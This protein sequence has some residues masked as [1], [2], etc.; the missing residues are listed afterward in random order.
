MIA[1]IGIGVFGMTAVM[2]LPCKDEKIRRWGYVLGVCAQPFWFYET[3]TKEQWGI[4]FLSIFYSINW[5]RGVW[6]HWV[7]LD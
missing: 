3:Y 7:D 2:L 5:L 1:Q 4:F 6:N